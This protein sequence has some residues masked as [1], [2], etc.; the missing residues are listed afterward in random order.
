M[1]SGSTTVS[2]LDGMSSFGSK[3]KVATASLGTHELQVEGS[4]VNY[5]RM[6]TRPEAA[7]IRTLVFTCW[8]IVLDG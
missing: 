2:P 8:Q 4:P 3:S 6:V 1:Q 5:D 7:T